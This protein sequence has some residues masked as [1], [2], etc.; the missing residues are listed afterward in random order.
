MRGPAK[1]VVLLAAALFGA[2]LAL[3]VFLMLRPPTSTAADT[4]SAEVSPAAPSGCPPSSTSPDTAASLAALVKSVEVARQATPTPRQ[5]PPK[6][7]QGRAAVDG[8]GD[9]R[10]TRALLD[11]VQ[12]RLAREK[13]AEAWRREA[14]GIRAAL[15]R[16]DEPSPE[17]RAASLAG[18]RAEL[19]DVLGVEDSDAQVG[20]LAE[21]LER[22]N[23]EA[24]A[25]VQ[26]LV[27]FDP[28][29]WRAALDVVRGLYRE[30]DAAVL[31][32]YGPAAADD[33]RMSEVDERAA[34]LAIGA[35][36]V[37]VPWSSI[38]DRTPPSSP[39]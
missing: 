7:D 25:E 3:N 27:A 36:L 23:D 22:S 24:G 4:S 30:Q 18:K 12:C 2:S 5:Q 11:D 37:G 32:V 20:Q 1:P 33:W 39:P 19:A 13:A 8:F 15:M 21:Q 14:E 26:R 17:Q 38:D 31:R 35:S 10:V 6:G 28:P 34:I 9:G 29:D 16:D